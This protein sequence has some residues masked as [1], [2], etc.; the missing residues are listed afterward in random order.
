VADGSNG[1]TSTTTNGI[2]TNPE[3]AHAS[4]IK[5]KMSSEADSTKNTVNG[6]DDNASM[7]PLGKGAY[8]E[9]AMGGQNSNTTNTDGATSVTTET[10]A[11]RL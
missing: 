2:S 8:T 5:D 4:D 10:P 6:A 7:L 3:E 1:P 11:R 9:P